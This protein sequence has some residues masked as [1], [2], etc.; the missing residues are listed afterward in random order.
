[1]SSR[2]RR[3][4]VDMPANEDQRLLCPESGGW[5]ERPKGR[6]EDRQ[7]CPPIQTEAIASPQRR[8]RRGERLSRGT[9]E[10]CAAGSE[11]SEMKVL[12]GSATG[13]APSECCANYA[14]LNLGFHVGVHSWPALRIT[15]PF[16][17][18]ATD[19]AEKRRTPQ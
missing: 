18:T 13:S 9:I 6:Q 12:Q 8:S 10:N 5:T 16:S 19:R 14:R 3:R 7:Q 17:A 11:R 2:H 15:T 1:M 4:Q